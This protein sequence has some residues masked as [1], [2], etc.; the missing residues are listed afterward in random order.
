[1]TLRRRQL[2]AV[3]ALAAVPGGCALFQPPKRAFIVFFAPDSAEP[4][5]DARRVLDDAA[6]AAT[7]FS[8]EKVYLIGF[9]D[10]EGS[11]EANRQLSRAR[12]DAVAQALAARGVAPRRFVQSARGATQP[13][14]AMVESRRVEI[15][16]GE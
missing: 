12:A 4:P 16:I 6:E 5:D 1:M 3:P 9:A 14:L 13:T 7:R 8:N 10:P 15:R 11:T 2:V